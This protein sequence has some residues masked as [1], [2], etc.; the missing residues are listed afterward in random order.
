MRATVK[1]CQEINLKI[2][3]PDSRKIPPT[4]PNFQNTCSRE[5]H[6]PNP[7]HT[8]EP[9]IHGSPHF[10][11]RPGRM[12]QSPPLRQNCNQQTRPTRRT[13]RTRSATSQKRSI[14]EHLR[15]VKKA[16]LGKP[17]RSIRLYIKECNSP[18]PR[19]NPIC[20]I[21]LFGEEDY[22]LDDKTKSDPPPDGWRL[23]VFY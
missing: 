10:H 8:Y 15:E 2:P 6:S 18:F 4:D 23:E 17:R 12:A 19:N 1:Y 9:K 14:I 13:K 5:H 22:F 3:T 7:K 16:S 20:A 21:I 11:H